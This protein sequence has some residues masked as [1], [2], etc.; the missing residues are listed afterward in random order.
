LFRLKPIFAGTPSF[1]AKQ[2]QLVG[3]K[4]N[5]YKYHIYHNEDQ[6]SKDD[7]IRTKLTDA[8]LNIE[9]ESIDIALHLYSLSKN[10]DLSC[11]TQ[12]DEKGGVVVDLKNF[13]SNE[14]ADAFIGQF[15]EWLKTRINT[16]FC[17]VIQREKDLF[18]E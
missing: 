18:T 4:L 2:V 13:Q 11:D 3:S 16:R 6:C 9:Y 10:F 8:Q 15:P 7:Q 14:E 1:T 5:N 12:Y 17:P